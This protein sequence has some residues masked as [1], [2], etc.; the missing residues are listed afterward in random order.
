MRI[1]IILLCMLS[2][3]FRVRSQTPGF[4]GKITDSISGH[5][6]PGASV[7]LLNTLRAGVADAEG[8]F[9]FSS[10]PAGKY[11]CEITAMGYASI[12]REI[13]VG[14]VRTGAGAAGDRLFLLQRSGSSL[15][16][17]IVTAQ[18][19]EELLQ[20]VP[21]AVSALT[22][23]QVREYR[24]WD[25]KDISAIVPSLYAAD[26]GDDRN[27]SSIR[28]ITSSSYD[29]AVATYIDGVNQF[30]LD[31]YIANL[32]DVERVEVLR[33]PQGTL[34]GR[35][36]MGGVINIITKQP[37][38]HA[39]GFA[40][41]D[42]GNYGRERFSAGFRA[43]LIKDRLYIGVA[44]V[45]DRRDGYYT[46]E[47]NNKPFD[48]QH[49][50]TCNYYLRY[51]PAAHWSLG[52]NVKHHDNRNDGAFPSVIG[53]DEAFAHPFK[54]DQNAVT[55][56]VDNTLNASFSV[57]YMGSGFNFSSQ[58]AYQSNYRYYKTPIDADFSPL[59]GIV[60]DKNYGK[61]W[62]KVK[63]LT[64]DLKFSSPA[65]SL[66]PWKWTAG[67]YAFY[68]DA[69]N[70]QATIF[71]KDANLLGTGD[72]LF[73]LINTTSSYRWGASVYGQVV[74]ALSPIFN[75][76]I[77]GRYD[78]EHQQENILG[79]Y[80]HDPLPDL[81]VTRPDTSG[82]TSYGA[83]SPKLSLDYQLTDR[84]MVYTVY[85]RG[86]RA[87]GLTEL[88]SDP[89]TP[90]L[91]AFRPEYSNN[92]EIGIKNTW[93][94]NTLRFNADLFYSRVNDAQVPTLVLPDAITVTRNTGRLDSKGVEAEVFA[95]PVKGLSLGYSFGY[96][97]ARFKDLKVSQNGGVVDLAGKHQVFT[98]EITSML[99]V[100]YTCSFG[101][102][103]GWQALLRGEWKQM[104]TTYF[105]QANELSQSPY[106]LLNTRLGITHGDYELMFWGRNLGNKKYI[107]YAYDF[108]AVHLGDPRTLGISLCARFH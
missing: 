12:D 44:G 8:R 60:L 84:S 82:R 76:T 71:G 86:F 13:S 50:F 72:S 74:Y 1:L 101:K 25:I 99:A 22:A 102:A 63:V 52:L 103:G 16:E 20:K 23:K 10:L 97:N 77:G 54:L 69:P 58:S 107:G 21:I 100:Q 65:S 89:N 47:F 95:A 7:R 46:N 98:P 75:I 38:N 61:N 28:G 11:L 45:Y 87:G 14:S 92:Y 96:T 9:T 85:S 105:D 34:Y 17:V 4:T 29:P 15:D 35:N 73:S 83:F 18:K 49:S 81:I 104:G 30:T 3:T 43:P 39:D 79:E 2:M 42:L 32:F 51:L 67:A 70:K 40:G 88:S 59:D 5:P 26:P 93:L 33:G 36:A 80:Q 6:I 91:R 41:V 19:K 78:H 48:S 62:N 53:V 55:T 68:Q 27:V 64:Q 90:P 108:G 66:S 94:H 106:A 37:S 31:T 57:N 24:L 56:M